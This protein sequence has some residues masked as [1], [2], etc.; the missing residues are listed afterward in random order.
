LYIGADWGNQLW[1][2]GVNGTTNY[3]IYLSHNA[4]VATFNA[5][6]FTGYQGTLGFFPTDAGFLPSTPPFSRQ[7]FVKRAWGYYSNVTGR[8]AIMEPI[9]V[10]TDAAHMSRLQSLLG[11]ETNS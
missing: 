8:G 3:D 7:L 2:R 9:K 6:D 10:S 5:A 4:G 11:Q 1:A